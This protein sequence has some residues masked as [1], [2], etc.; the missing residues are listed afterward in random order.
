MRTNVYVDGFNLYYGRLKKSAYK[1]LDLRSLIAK[2]LPQNQ[3]NTIKYFTAL[4]DSEPSDPDKTQRQLTYIRALKATQVEVIQGKF[5]SS[6]VMMPLVSPPSG[7]PRLVKVHKREEKGSDVNLATHL[8]LDAFRQ[9]FDI[10]V[11]VSNDT[12]LALP[13]QVV[14]ND[15]RLD[16]GVLNPQSKTSNYLQKV[17][18]FYREL[19]LG[20][21]KSSQFPTSLSDQNGL[22]VK[23]ARW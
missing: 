7:G 1:W 20:P 15:F 3:I 19:R 9:H 2:V 11:I 16:V 12:D 22:I 14:R 10:A 17:A 23:P 4:V 13:I 6:E 18:S 5:L 8:L 21:I